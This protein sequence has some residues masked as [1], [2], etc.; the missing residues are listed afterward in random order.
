M[1]TNINDV[2]DFIRSNRMTVN[3]RDLI[4]NAVNV[5][6]RRLGQSI[7]RKLSVGMT[8]SF[9]S[10]KR[11]RMVIGQVDKINNV[12]VQLT[13]NDTKVK[14]RVSPELLKL[15]APEFECLKASRP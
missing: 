11:D 12:T 2:L 3:E 7:A 5:A 9:Y 4:V 10:L 14:W 1:I 13:E 6:K 15:G 8:V